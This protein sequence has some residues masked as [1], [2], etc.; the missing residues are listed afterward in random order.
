MAL[1]AFGDLAVSTISGLPPGRGTVTTRVA[2]SFAA[3]EDAI[4]EHL[5][6]DGRAFVVCPRISANDASDLNAGNGYD[7]LDDNS[8]TAT[9]TAAPVP[10]AI[11]TADTLRARFPDARVEV[12]YGGLSDDDKLRAVSDF[13]HGACRI[14][15]ATTVIE[16]GV[17]CPDATLMAVLGAERFGLAQLHQLRGRIGRGQRDGEAL[18]VT[19]DPSAAQRLSVL[20]D[21][22]DGFTIAETDLQQRGPGEILGT[23]Q[24]GLPKLLVADLTK[25][26]DL[27][28][29]AHQHVHAAAQAAHNDLPAVLDPCL[30]RMLTNTDHGDA[31]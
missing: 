8:Q 6:A 23:R 29:H 11:E 12:V 2:S 18:L 7:G 5:A 30:E 16:V 10:A 1:T 3:L 20:V 14:L 25:D 13:A 15:V 22:N 9:A 31:G 24:H 4:S 21:S 17:D 28:Q 19:H 27:L 26:L